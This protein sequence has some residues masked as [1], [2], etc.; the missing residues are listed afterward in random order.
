MAFDELLLS[1]MVLLVRKVKKGERERERKKKK[2][3]R[4]KEK[5]KE[6]ERPLRRRLLLEDIKTSN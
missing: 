6:R 1:Q 4:E 5:K 2:R 3:E